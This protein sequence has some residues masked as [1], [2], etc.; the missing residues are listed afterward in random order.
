MAKAIILGSDR[1]IRRIDSAQSYPLALVSDNSG[2]RVL[3]WI[4]D[5]LNKVF[6]KDI[7][8]V[9]GYHIEKMVQL[10]PWMR[11]YYNQ[12]WNQGGELQALSHAS[13]EL[14]ESCIIV[15]SDVV[16]RPD[17]ISSLLDVDADI[18]IATHSGSIAT[19]EVIEGSF[20]GIVS[21]SA[22]AACQL[23]L[24]IQELSWDVDMA[25]SNGLVDLLMSFGLAT[26]Y[27]N[28]GNEWTRIDSPQSLSQFVFGT[29]AQTLERLQSIVSEA[30]ILDQ[31]R[32]SALEWNENPEA[33]MGR[34]TEAIPKVHLV[35]RSSAYNE[36]TW[37]KS[38]AG[39]YHSELG[40]EGNNPAVLRKA[41]D[42]VCDSFVSINGS[43][44]L[45]DEVFVQAHLDDVVMSGVLFTRNPETGAPYVA[46]NYDDTSSTTDTVTSGK[47]RDLSTLIV[48]K[49][50]K[51]AFQGNKY[52]SHLMKVVNE[53]EGLLGHDALD[54]EFAFDSSD[55][56][57]LLQVRV[58][59]GYGSGVEITDVD[60]DEE[61]NSID[62]YVGKLLR[63]K[64][65]LL[66]KKTILA[67]MPDWNPAELIGVS[68][69]PLALSLY[70]YLITDRVWGKARVMG[71]YRDT[72][73]TPLVVAISGHPYVDTRASLNSFL[74][75]SLT[76]NLGDKLVNYCVECLNDSPE[77]HDKFEF[78]VAFTC[79]DF[80]FGTRSQE[81]MSNNFSH[82]EIGHLRDGLRSL[83]DDIVCQ[84][85]SSID[86]QMSI[87]GK[88]EPRRSQLMDMQEDNVLSI[89]RTID[90]LLADCVQFGTL[91]FAMI[92]R[93]AFIAMAL[94][95]SLCSRGVLSSEE[96]D[97]ILQTI[98][99][100][101]SDITSDLHLLSTDSL[102]L[103]TFLGRYGHLRPGTFD[104][105]SLS[106]REA[107]DYYLG[108]QVNSEK[109]VKL[110]HDSV[111]IASI[112]EKHTLAINR[113]IDESGFTFD[114]RQM[115]SFIESSIPARELIKF[116]YTKNLSAALSLIVSLGEHLGL[117]RDDVSFLPIHRLLDVS[118]NSPSNVLRTELARM[119]TLSRKRYTL[120]TAIK[121]PHMISSVSDLVYFKLLK[122]Q[123][124]FI[125][126]KKVV[127][128]VTTIDDRESEL[129]LTGKIIMIESADPGY[130]WIFGHQISGL[131]TKYGGAASHMAIRASELELPAAIGCGDI[132]YDELLEANLIELDCALEL[133]RVL[134]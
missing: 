77:L 69:R 22:R 104:I 61:L 39:V 112:L 95:K 10:Y 129:D 43:N 128:E 64:S 75:A 62:D 8:F 54:I 58:L 96:F 41:I 2:H 85:I 66:G 93:N 92:A 127:G 68:P 123:P 7:V 102:S 32:F 16:F 45:R 19:D 105:T 26:K 86:E 125:T 134:Q 83:T 46:I 24:S 89:V 65:P 111:G 30:T 9:G 118:T 27:V 18:V 97:S 21:L 87:V 49:Y 25:S 100:V 63:F 121:L 56:C 84:R 31:V 106:Y 91:P 15:R 28:I 131:V 126:S 122:W 132:I 42:A 73:S 76:A 120:Q 50:E 34:I 59:T 133:V 1:G 29:K 79:L 53:L 124:N 70:Q 67:D 3:D 116:E 17:A 98:P 109:F 115:C 33:V 103:D 5:S 119:I 74:P 6:L 48:Y 107:P 78:S 51:L 80:D 38:Q 23:Q 108:K 81:L 36:D 40:V 47:G 14:T 110:E 13:A 20:A 114:L 113:L 37:G 4:L 101:A 72:G 130:D 12:D 71:G 82:E 117:S 60:V 99:T 57:Y 52:I 90:A 55:K 94:L 88:L 11:F 35:V 44:T